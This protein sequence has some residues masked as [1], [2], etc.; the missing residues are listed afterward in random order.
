MQRLVRLIAHHPW[1]VLGAILIVTAVLAAPLVDLEHRRLRLDVD[2]STNRLLPENQPGRT[3]YD[4]VRKAFGSDETMVVALSAED[5]FTH[6][7]LSRIAKLSE[8]LTRVEGVHHVVAI[9]NVA[10]VIGMT[11]RSPPMRRMSCSPCS[12]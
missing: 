11:R 9:T 6:D 2:M 1:V 10:N 4:Y 12:A 3:F 8:R 5:I 7:V